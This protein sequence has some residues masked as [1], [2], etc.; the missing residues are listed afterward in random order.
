MRTT[1]QEK[2]IMMSKQVN[3]LRQGGHEPQ[4]DHC[5]SLLHDAVLFT[6]DRLDEMDKESLAGYL[7]IAAFAVHSATPQC[8]DIRK[9]LV[10]LGFNT[11]PVGMLN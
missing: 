2:V 8:R 6:G 11:A 3:E 10:D 4:K 1:M 7:E 9:A 5:F